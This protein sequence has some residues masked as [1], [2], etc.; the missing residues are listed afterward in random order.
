MSFPHK[1]VAFDI[2]GTIAESKQP[3]TQ[4]MASLLHELS[5]KTKVAI[6]SGASF[7]TFNKQLFP[8]LKPSRN[9][10]LL[11]VEGSERFEYDEAGKEWRMTDKEVFPNEL[12]KKV[13][14]AL[15]DIITSGKYDIPEKPYGKY[16]D[17]RETEIAFSA[18]GQ[19]APL[20]KKQAWDPDRTKRTKIKE[21]LDARV[22]GLMTV[23]SGTTSIDIL[24]AGFNKAKGLNIFLAKLGYTKGEMMYVG[25][26]LFPGGN[27][28]AVSEAGIK[29][30]QVNSLGE[31]KEVIRNILHPIAYFC[32]EYA[33]DVNPAMYAGGLGILAADYVLEAAD[34][35]IPF[36]A[37]GLRYG[38]SVPAG[39]EIM[40]NVVIN[41]PIGNEVI[42]AQVW[43]RAF[44][45]ATH[46]YLLDAGDITAR[47]Y[48]MD[49]YTRVKQQIVLGIG[50]VRLLEKLGITPRIYH[51]NEGH[52]AFAALGIM[53]ERKSDLGKIVAT[54]HT[55]LSAAGLEITFADLEKLIGPY[56]KEFH[57]SFT[58]ICQKG[59]FDLAPDLFS[60]TKFMLASAVRKN[61]VS[62]IHA[63]FE[64]KVHPQ[65]TLISVTNGVYRKRWQTPE[66]LHRSPALSDVELWNTKKKLKKEL[67][68][69]VEKVSGTLLNPDICTLVWARR[70]A[71]YKRPSLLFSDLERLTA[72]ISNPNMPLQIIIS[73]K[74]HEGDTEA[75][76]IRDNIIAYSKSGAV[77]GRT[78]YL[79]D[80][81]VANAEKLTRGA[82]IWL[83]TPELGL[84][85]CGT[86]GMK[87]SLNG[88]LQCSVS[89]GWV[90]E[91]NWVGRGWTFE[92]VE[93]LYNL[94]EHEIVPCY[95]E[96]KEWVT[97][98]ISTIE[99]VE[100]EYTAVRMIR[101]YEERLYKGL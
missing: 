30:I 77:K 29:S 28:Y 8:T 94:L 78:I 99:L 45:T 39:F 64:K 101:D 82:D 1:L 72:I 20:D 98:M 76:K 33:L 27:D 59:R 96:G 88:A 55:I 12:K 15:N 68:D 51:L 75:E 79:S 10:I 42:K 50:G 5:T 93:M 37:V 9:I 65:S 11:P 49:F 71:G 97:R 89:D 53:A 86:S 74:P 54:K 6:I 85:A 4:E 35:N 60:T 26:E 13:I 22:D 63:V 7:S 43:H 95:Y 70:F 61:G 58:E 14:E 47:L 19:E 21:A 31:T 91:V 17:D 40:E 38:K 23:V 90:D 24:P 2:D 100:K 92:T 16:I 81:S 69:Y 73:G 52:T 34:Q 46:V 84:E 80:Y 44:S 18:L 87:A 36:I 83:N 41:V 62:A 32:S 56:C 57:I 25:D 66:F 48:D 67:F 3:M